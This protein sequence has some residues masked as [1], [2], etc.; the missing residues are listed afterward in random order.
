[1]SR[2]QVVQANWQRRRWLIH[3]IQAQEDVIPAVIKATLSIQVKVIGALLRHRQL[4]KEPSDIA[5]VDTSS[6]L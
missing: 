4:C 6:A 5:N 1:M 3:K 2:K